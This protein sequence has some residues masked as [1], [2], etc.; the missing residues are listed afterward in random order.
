MSAVIA[1]RPRAMVVGCLLNGD[2]W[3]SGPPAGAP[4][5]PLVVLWRST[6]KSVRDPACT[7]VRPTPAERLGWRTPP[8]AWGGYLWITSPLAAFRDPDRQPPAKPP[9]SPLLAAFFSPTP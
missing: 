8:A 7:S 5:R 4:A 1:E 6:S 2:G 9:N 3:L